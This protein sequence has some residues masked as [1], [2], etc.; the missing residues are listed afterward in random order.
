M[1]GHNAVVSDAPEEAET[2]VGIRPTRRKPI[3]PV[4]RV[5]LAAAF[6]AVVVLDIRLAQDCDVEDTLRALKRRPLCRFRHKRSYEN[7]L[8]SELSGSP[9]GATG[10]R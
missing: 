5:I 9:G 1:T 10:I 8:V 6:G 3:K 2:V 7:E 4:L